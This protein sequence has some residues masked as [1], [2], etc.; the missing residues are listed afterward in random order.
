[1]LKLKLQYFAYLLQREDTLGKTKQ[2]KQTK[3]P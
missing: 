2:N 3:K 1:M